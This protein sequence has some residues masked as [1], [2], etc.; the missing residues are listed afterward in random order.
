MTEKVASFKT[1]GALWFTDLTTPDTSFIFPVLI[2]GLTLWIARECDT[3]LGL[4]GKIVT[5]KK[6]ADRLYVIL[7]LIMGMFY[8]KAVH[9]SMMSSM[10]FSIVFMYGEFRSNL[11]G[12]VIRFVGF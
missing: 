2:T 6:V 11:V 9:C 12:S 7:I 5:I 8:S 3:L 1:G 4:E 10:L